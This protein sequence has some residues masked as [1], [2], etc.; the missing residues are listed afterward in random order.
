MRR[1]RALLV[2]AF[3]LMLTSSA[4]ANEPVLL[5]AAGSLRG[6]LTEVAE[7]F[8]AESGVKVEAKYGPSGTDTLSVGADYGMTV[9]NDSPAAAYRFALIIVS[10]KGRRILAKH[11]FAALALP[12]GEHR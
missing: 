7:A 6:A 5:L 9:M 12:Q 8:A 11:G 4:D 2:A 3:G 10:S 1:V